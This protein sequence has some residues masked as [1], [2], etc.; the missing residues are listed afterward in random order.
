MYL[1]VHHNQI[2]IST[3]WLFEEAK[4]GLLF[5]ILN[6]YILKYDVNTLF[7]D[8]HSF[9]TTRYYFNLHSIVDKSLANCC[10]NC[11]QE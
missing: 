10:I 3:F 2:K 9:T 11:S 8:L 6:R 1:N 7:I 4:Q 5:D